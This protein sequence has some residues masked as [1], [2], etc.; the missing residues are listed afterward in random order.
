M[1]TVR[2]EMSDIEQGEAGEAM[3]DRRAA[4][5]GW[6]DPKNWLAASGLLI[7]IGLFVMGII[8]NQLIAIS[9]NLQAQAI[10]AAKLVT[11]V[12][13][14]ES[15]VSQ[16]KTDTREIDKKVDG[17]EKTQRDYNFNLSTR[18]ATLTKE[19]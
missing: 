8:A 13:R 15:D 3:P 17:N 2:N 4:P 14:I 7:T 11:R 19:K 1:H 10:A 9:T 5:S 6:S 16:V 18:L 12:D